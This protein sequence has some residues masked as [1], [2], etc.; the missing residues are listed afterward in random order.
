MELPNFKRVMRGY[1]PE[2]V[3]QA[4]ADLQRQVAEANASNKE[5]R[6]QINSLREQ[7][8]EWGNRLKAYEK[9]ERDLRDAL[10]SAQR[11][12]AQLQDEAQQKAEELLTSARSESE[13]TIAEAHKL[14]ELK[15]AEIDNLIADKRHEQITLEQRIEELS[16]VK[17]DLERR[18][19]QAGKYVNEILYLFK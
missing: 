2:A 10:L 3:E 12:A 13:K 17:D 6:L 19:E 15:E 5:L 9:M 1:D 11:I 7:N 4:W 8:N 16:Q 14:A 18:V